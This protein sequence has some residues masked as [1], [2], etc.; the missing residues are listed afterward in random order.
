MATDAGDTSA[1][2][3]KAG[4]HVIVAGT[5]AH[6]TVS[7]A[8]PTPLSLLH[9]LPAPPHL[10][11]RDAVLGELIAAVRSGA[12]GA[13]ISGVQGM[14][15][16]G[17]TALA[18][19]LAHGVKDLYP[20]AQLVFNL[21]GFDAQGLP[22]RDPAEIMRDVILRFRPESKPPEEPDVL[23]AA[24]LSVL[25]DAGRVLLL[26]DNAV[27]A[28]QVEPL[29]PPHGCLMLVTSRTRFSLAGMVTRDIEC[30]HPDESAAMLRAH[31]PRIAGYE[32]DA[33]ALCGHLPLKL[34][35]F[36]AVVRA[37]TVTAVE[38]LVAMLRE[39]HADV[40][41]E[42]A[43][44]QVSYELLDSA[45]QA[46]LCALGIF[47][48]S[49]DLRAA[50]AIW[51]LSEAEAGERAMQELVDESLVEFSTAVARFRLHDLMRV[52]CLR[53]LPAKDSDALHLAHARHYTAVGDEADNLYLSGD[54]VGG[55]A[56]FDR[57]RAPIEAAYARLAERGDEAAT[58]QLLAL[59]SAVVYTSD[60]RFHP[61]QRIAWLESHLR[62]A[63]LVGVKRHEGNA[64]GNLGLAHA[65]LGDARKAIGY[66][67]QALAVSREIGDRRGEGQDLGNLGNAHFFLGDARQA[68]G[69]YE[70]QLA[71][72][73]EIGYRRGE[74]NA[75]GSLGNAHADLG[76]AR[77]AIEYCDLRLAIAREIG[78]R[79]GEGNALFNSALAHNS[80]GNRSEAIA[81]AAAALAIY[82][83][84]ESPHA[85][86]VRTA[87]AELRAQ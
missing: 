6:V 80:L 12:A 17:K 66:H 24:Y 31:A 32:A 61:R 29:V 43:A 70:Q 51:E 86:R 57:E 47:T 55:L 41:P 35:V 72:T 15:G 5:G 8:A 33:A 26:F 50:A 59:V 85:A 46:R 75:L 40:S 69:Y 23:R 3:V 68:I 54:A 14:P 34:K 83:A 52:F 18:E 74:G 28:A 45:Q 1:N 19:A 7:N 2:N 44:F 27:G 37:R 21:R 25:N 22:P 81:R 67:E 84:I 9:N 79:R 71:I 78:D 11:G 39:R 13:A 16:V 82:E 62:A 64:L 87:L 4:G 76:D 60:L 65:A 30:L 42:D 77:K 53:K 73:R 38:R 36:A 48:S 20:A 49:F 58:R 56:L 10:F 63:R